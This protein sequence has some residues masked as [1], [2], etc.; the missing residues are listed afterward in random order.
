MLSTRAAYFDLSIGPAAKRELAE[1]V[2]QGSDQSKADR[3][4]NALCELGLGLKSVRVVAQQQRRKTAY[5][6]GLPTSASPP[7]PS[8]HRTEGRG[9]VP[10]GDAMTVSEMA[11]RTKLRAVNMEYSALVR[12]NRGEG[13]FVRMEELRAERVALMALIAERRLGERQDSASVALGSAGSIELPS[14][15]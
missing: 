15:I 7:P 3:E 9:I 8:R 12:G 13:R 4:N 11:L 1:R 2:A 10:E 6:P 5:V 14:A